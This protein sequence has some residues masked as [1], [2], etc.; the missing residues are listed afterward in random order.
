MPILF[1]GGR[2]INALFKGVLLAVHV[3]NEQEAVEEPFFFVIARVHRADV[4]RK[5]SGS[6]S[7]AL[8]AALVNQD[9]VGRVR[10]SFLPERVKACVV[11][12]GRRRLGRGKERSGG[13]AGDDQTKDHV[14]NKSEERRVGKEGTSRWS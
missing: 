6:P 10:R 3:L 11:R 13:K 1:V 12:G 14:N 2:E 8:R 5:F 9:H 4:R 7:R